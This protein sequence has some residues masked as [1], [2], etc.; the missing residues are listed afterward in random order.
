MKIII[1]IPARLESTRVP[2]KLLLP[3]PDNKPL[4]YFAW[5]QAI[6]SSANETYIATDNT[7]VY[8]EAIKFGAK[9]IITKSNHICGT[10]RIAEAYNHIKRGTHHGHDIDTDYIINL[11]GD[12]PEIRSEDIN[13]L[14][15]QFRNWGFTHW[16][17]I[18]TLAVPFHDFYQYSLPQ[19]V[20]VVFDRLNKAIYFSRGRIPWVD[21]Q[22]WKDNEPI[23]YKHIGIYAYTPKMLEKFT[24][25]EV[26]QLEQIEGLEQM[27][28]IENHW[29]ILV[30]P[31]NA[32]KNDHI[33]PL[34]INTRHDYDI[35]LSRTRIPDN[36]GY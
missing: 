12:E 29:P 27:R 6:E 4:L 13:L 26:S 2:H 28:A 33:W 11:Q 1:I 14:I 21:I 17:K 15:D 32:P 8:Q 23:A 10:D 20:K 3:G 19:N 18:T 25:T 31:I 30:I 16:P 5:K 24:K 34:G 7:E 9:V 35:W 22:N 36:I